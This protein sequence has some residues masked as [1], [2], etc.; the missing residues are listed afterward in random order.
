MRARQGREKRQRRGSVGSVDPSEASEGSRNV[1]ASFKFLQESPRRKSAPPSPTQR[2]GHLDAAAHPFTFPGLGGIDLGTTKEPALHV[3]SPVSEGT[4]DSEDAGAGEDTDGE[5]EESGDLERE[6]PIP[7]SM[8]A[9]RAP[10]PLDFNHPVLTDTVSAGLFKA[11]AN[12]GSDSSNGNNAGAAKES[13]ERTRRIV[14]SRL[15]SRE[16]FEHVS[17]LSRDGSCVPV[18]SQNASQG[19]LVTDPGRWDA[20]NPCSRS[21]LSQCVS[22]VHPFLRW[23]VSVPRP[24]IRQAP[25]RIFYAAS[26]YNNTRSGLRRFLRAS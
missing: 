14:R 1:M 12:G 4:Q 25:H 6:L 24:Q 21:H 18:I 17:R 23:P 19:W 10:I 9:R 26:S 11:L 20:P 2:Q 8:K 16:I 3:E 7:L 13:E 15:S 22:A 5:A